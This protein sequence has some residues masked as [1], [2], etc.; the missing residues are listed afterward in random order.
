MIRTI[1]LRK[2]FG[3]FIACNDLSISLPKNKLTALLGRNG[4]GKTTLL[5][6]L[7][8]VLPPTSGAILFEGIADDKR[9]ENTGTVF[10]NAPVYPQLTVSEFLGLSASVYGLSSQSG[11]VAIQ[12]EL[13]RWGLQA[14]KNRLCGNLS[15]GYRQRLA[16][17]RALLTEPPVLLLDEPTSGLDPLESEHFREVIRDISR[18]TTIIFSTHILSEVSD[19]ADYLIILEKG[20]KVAEGS[21]RQIM[22]SSGADTLERAFSQY[23]QS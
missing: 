7:A 1:V 13:E 8:S 23:A 22:D 2:I 15:R 4:A 20:N 17:A 6:M 18:T 5:A 14:E 21:I 9:R 16:L 12:R 11:R 3:S 10:E 19:L